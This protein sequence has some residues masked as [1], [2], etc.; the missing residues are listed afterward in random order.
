MGIRVGEFV[1]LLGPSGCGKSVLLRM[2]GGFE[3]STSGRIWLDG[4]EVTHLPPNKREVNMVFQD[5]ALF[6]H[7]SV[8]RN[9]GYGLCVSGMAKAEIEKRARETLALVGHADKFDV[10]PH[11]MSGDQRQRVSLARTSCAGPSC[12]MSR[13]PLSMRT[14]ARSCRWNCVTCTRR[15]AS[16]S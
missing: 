5:Y 8:G 10:R 4:K 7:M 13:S 2:I 16:P 1:T 15:S 12:S 6:P 9:V 11:Q 14:C 3:E